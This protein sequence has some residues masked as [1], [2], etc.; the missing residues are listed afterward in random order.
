MCERGKLALEMSSVGDWLNP[1]QINS[2]A[3]S[4]STVIGHNLSFAVKQS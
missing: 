4:S 2:K 3:H 1:V